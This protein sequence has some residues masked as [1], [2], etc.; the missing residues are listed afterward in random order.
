M[1]SKAAVAAALFRDKPCPSAV[2]RAGR[3][4]FPSFSV[5][6]FPSVVDVLLMLRDHVLT[7][8]HAGGA[9]AARG[10]HE[11][12]PGE[13]FLAHERAPVGLCL[14]FREHRHHRPPSIAPM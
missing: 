1:A 12:R 10:A 6:P 14:F 4:R 13:K 9:D 8:R 7:P 11:W 3:E 5:W 2:S